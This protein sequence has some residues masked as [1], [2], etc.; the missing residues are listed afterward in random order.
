M[1]LNK[2]AGYNNQLYITGFITTTV[3]N[4]NFQL[5]LLMKRLKAIAKRPNHS[6][7]FRIAIIDV[8][9]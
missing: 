1:K 4:R 2:L 9:I 7:K 6:I 3:E 8:I 5:C